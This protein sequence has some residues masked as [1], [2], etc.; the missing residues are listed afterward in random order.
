M[1]ATAPGNREPRTAPRTLRLVN[2][3]AD[4]SGSPTADTVVLD[5][6]WTPDPANLDEPRPVRPVLDAVL[7]ADNLFLASLS[8]LDTWADACDLPE[9]FAR[10]GVTWWFHARSFLRLDL[11][12]LLLW[13]HVLD[14][15]APAGTYDRIVVPRDRPLLA[16]AIRARATD[17]PGPEVRLETGSAFSTSDATG[18]PHARPAKAD[19]P[20]AAVVRSVA[21]S[22]R[23]ARRALVRLAILPAREDRV[24]V[25]VE[26]LRAQA[27]RP[28]ATLAIVRANSFHTVQA[29]GTA[30]RRDPYIGPVLARL[31]ASGR[32][33][34]TL[35]LGMT[36]RDLPDWQMILDDPR[37]LPNSF[38]RWLPD[39]TADD[40]TTF[41]AEAASR[42]DRMPVVPIRDGDRDLGPAISAIVTSLG[43]WLARQWRDMERAGR[44]M[45]VL[46]PGG[47]LTG[48]EATRTAWL[49]A[50]RSRGIPAFAIQHGVIYPDTPD[51]CRPEHAALVRPDVTCVYGPYERG[52]LTG[53]GGYADGAV[54]ATGSPRVVP[55]DLLEPLTPEVRA[56]VR[57]QLGVAEGDRLLVISG[58]RMTVGDRLG[59]LP[60]VARV[61]DGPLPGIHVVVKLHPEEHDGE[62]YRDLITGLARAGG[63]E[64]PPLTIVRD[65]D[66]YRL[67]RAAD[68]HLGVYSTVLTDSVLAGT[69]N[70][71]VVGQAQAD[72]LGYVE[73]G[74]AVPVRSVGDVRA[75]MAD[76]R[77]P[78]EDARARFV[79]AH[80]VDGDAVER[81]GD[82]VM[83]HSLATPP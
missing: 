43:P 77:P 76:P 8:L 12:E 68:A 67:L 58:G 56:A 62:H 36:H 5:T 63:Y 23:L 55:A 33:S 24:A 52:I 21:R 28:G 44:L 74:V 29:G 49:G 16:D 17:A 57:A 34:V 9:R 7:D 35:A 59:T 81:I 41:N 25:L 65:I 4:A 11:Q 37:L 70:M 14:I 51:Y 50:A 61:M 2:V 27:D 48:W 46:R 26:R 64:A 83:R 60:L 30:V 72:M 31:A 82:I 54:I 32:D 39:G 80:F 69:P 53:Q 13:G 1:T 15:L 6:C 66:L 75:F 20:R 3:R 79:E 42:L 19:G 10:D 45:D 78:S 40:P 73:A 47:L 38:L 71:I 18:K 22:R